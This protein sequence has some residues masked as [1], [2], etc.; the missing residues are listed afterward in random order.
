MGFIDEEDVLQIWKY[1]ISEFTL[2]YPGST[3]DI[4]LERLTD[5]T[6]EN[7]YE[8]N[9]FPII[10]L[11]MSL[12]SNV[13]QA[14]V[15]NKN[16]VKIKL[17]I[18]KF[19]T[20][21]GSEEKSLMKDYINT[22]FSL[23]LDDTFQDN[24]RFIDE[25]EKNVTE[26]N[27]AKSGKIEG[28][29]E[30]KEFFIY[31]AETIQAART[32][33]NDVLSSVTMIGAIGYL[34][35]VS[36]VS[37]ILV[38]PMENNTVYPELLIPPQTSLSAIQYLDSEY[39]FYKSG[40][41][42]FFDIDRAYILNYKGGCT[43]WE[44]DEIQETC[45]MV[46]QKGGN[47]GANTCSVEK[48]GQE[49]VRKYICVSADNVDIKN[50]DISNDVTEGNNATI[51]NTNTN[52]IT[53]ANSGGSNESI[54]TTNS[55]NPWL[56][57]TYGAQKAANSVVVSLS[58]GDFDASAIAP[59]KKFVIL[60]ED[61]KYAEKYRGVYMITYSSLKFIKDGSDLKLDATLTFKITGGEVDV[62]LTDLTEDT[63]TDEDELEVFDDESENDV[64]DQDDSD[65]DDDE[66]D[67]DD[68][69]YD[70]DEDDEEDIPVFDEDW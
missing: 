28:T 11:N 40:S 25:Q 16:D 55:S 70:N 58:T 57:E 27:T 53:S 41:M 17:R 66:D 46:P 64:I 60:F 44:K 14:I 19:Y 43:A 42:I 18:Q 29:D 62:D 13:Y 52:T 35:S 50:Q 24:D 69:S 1:T 5:F 45:I 33:A 47:N 2:L 36:G 61:S 8:K 22:T 9:I 15:E 38:S 67:S 48:E 49:D 31:K 37:K 65:D 30:K 63:D 39:G 32:M 12:E 20:E 10:K 56:G 68:D 34:T 3:Y 7:D 51:I 4:P 54:I 21:R 23:I 59:N 6:I 26:D